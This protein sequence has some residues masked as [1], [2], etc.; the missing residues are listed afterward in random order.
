MIRHVPVL[1]KEIYQNLV[2]DNECIGDEYVHLDCN[3]GDG[4]HVEYF[5]EHLLLEGKYKKIS[6]YALDL[7]QDAIA[8]GK[9]FLK[10]Y[11]DNKQVSIQIIQGN[12]ADIKTLVEKISFNSILFDLGLSTYQLNGAGR[13][14]SF[15]FDEKLDM[16]FSTLEATEG[17]LTAYDIINFWS[18]DNLCLILRQYADET[19]AWRIANKIIEVREKKAIE[20]SGELAS[21]IQDQVFGGKKHKIHPATKTFQAL[22]IAVNSELQVLEK[23]L[24]GAYSVLAPEGR[25]AVISYHSLE[26]IIVKHYF[27]TLE[28]ESK[29]KRINKKIIIPTEEEVKSNPKSRSAKLRIFKK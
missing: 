8:R 27:K 16:R 3:F 10:K 18:L 7:D 20:T 5:I 1:A 11:E 4:G 14:F 29:G 6:M 17:E 22:R 12:F 24:E 2:I 13:G 23:G 9:D 15:K 19:S 28:E 25:I 26:D 21:I